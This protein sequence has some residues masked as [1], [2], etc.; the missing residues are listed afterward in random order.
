MLSLKIHN[1]KYAS[2]LT[3][4]AIKF[5]ANSFCIGCSPNMKID[6]LS[7]GQ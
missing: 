7:Q 3:G 4:F 2:S 6:S 5:N 1:V